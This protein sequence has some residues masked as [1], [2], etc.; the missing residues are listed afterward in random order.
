MRWLACGKVERQ[1]DNKPDNDV[2]RRRTL[3]CYTILLHSVPVES[4][5]YPDKTNMN[6]TPS[7]ADTV[8][9]MAVDESEDAVT[10]LNAV[11]ES[12]LL[13]NQIHP[14]LLYRGVSDTK[15]QLVPSAFRIDETSKRK[16]IDCSSLEGNR[17]SLTQQNQFFLEFNV[18][19]A[20]YTLADIQGYDFYSTDWATTPQRYFQA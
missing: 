15:H 19:R 9:I 17:V 18:V 16:L 6:S 12:N 2:H 11:R 5:N 7:K 8:G 4:H 13:S 10:F 14:R 20:F 3:A 1:R